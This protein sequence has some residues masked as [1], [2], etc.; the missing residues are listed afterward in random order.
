MLA[1]LDPKT[2]AIITLVVLG[3]V[4]GL[5]LA[6]GEK[7]PAGFEQIMVAAASTLFIAKDS[8]GVKK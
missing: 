8:E 3:A 4:Y 6:K 5:M 2:G 7:P 1:K